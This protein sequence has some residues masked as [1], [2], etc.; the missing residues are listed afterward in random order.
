MANVSRKGFWPVRYLN[1]SCWN[2]AAQVYAVATD[3]G[4]INIGDF[5]SMDGG[6]LSYGD[7]SYKTVVRAAATNTSVLGVLV[8]YEVSAPGLS[9]GRT[10]N[11]DNPITVAA[12]G[13]VQLVR[14]VD[15]MSV[16]FEGQTSST[17]TF[18]VTAL[19]LNCGLT[20]GT[21]DATNGISTMEIDSTTFAT[22]TT[23]P[24]RLVDVAN[25]PDN[26]SDT[27]RKVLVKINASMLY[28]LQGL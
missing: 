18:A 7:S 4:T 9:N 15:D 25:R 10:P 3:V 16:L 2:G 13:K 26:P 24:I 22:N 6:A 28:G 14:V 20:L 12:T 5:V 19:G 1:G 8:G 21:A 11:L 23:L 27:N 17:T